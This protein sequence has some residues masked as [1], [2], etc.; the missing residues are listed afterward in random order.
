MRTLEEWISKLQQSDKCIL[1]EGQKDKAALEELGMKNILMVSKMPTYKILEKIN[2][3]EVIILT[4]LDPEGKKVYATLR[5]H[6]QRKGIKID[7]VFREFLFK[8][9]TLT[10][11]EGLLHYLRKTSYIESKI[12]A[13]VLKL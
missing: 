13:P 12:G 7:K 6:L 9:T 5:H 10:H 1:V 2:E 11:I 3:K 4:D 8:H